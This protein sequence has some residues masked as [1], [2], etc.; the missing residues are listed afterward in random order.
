MLV[1]A[2]T[3]I[4]ANTRRQPPI[5]KELEN[6]A[7]KL[8]ARA[9]QKINTVDKRL[10]EEIRSIRSY[11]SKNTKEIH[12]KI[13][14]Y[15]VRNAEQIAKLNASLNSGFSDIQRTLGNIEGQLAAQQTQLA[16]GAKQ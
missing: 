14:G 13:E 4:R 8:E 16:G 15:H 5:E 6:L 2:L 12:E 9:D 10:T 3:Q 7:E 1:S 11:N